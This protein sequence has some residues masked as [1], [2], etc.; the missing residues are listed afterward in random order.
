[1]KAEDIS[2]IVFR[3]RYGHYEY[4][5]M[6][7]DVSNAPSVLMDY[8]IKIF[9]IYLDQF[10][11]V[12]IEDIMVY[13]KSYKEQADICKMCFNFLREKQLYARLSKCEF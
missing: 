12:F 5:R 6:L 11:V 9:H 8:I 3:T 10:V 1:M 7:F 4:S 2:K 13:S